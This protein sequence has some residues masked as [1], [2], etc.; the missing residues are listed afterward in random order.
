MNDRM[1][2]RYRI[3]IAPGMR[4]MIREGDGPGLEPRDAI[5]RFGTPAT[6]LS[7]NYPCLVGWNGRRKA[8]PRPWKPTASGAGL[9]DRGAGPMNSK[10]RHPQT[11]GKAG[12]FFRSV[13]DRT[14][15]H[16]SMPEHVAYCNE[17]RLHF[18][19]D[20]GNCPTPLKAFHA[21]NATYAIRE[22]NPRWMEAETDD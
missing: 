8:P 19:P 5:G 7:D 17:D 2:P 4:V 3:N 20:T 14:W 10:P 21:K 13:E 11:N 1:D 9:L 16:G 15:R 22:S 18:S 6:M 12:R